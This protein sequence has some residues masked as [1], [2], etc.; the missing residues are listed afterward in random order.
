MHLTVF[1]QNLASNAI[2]HGENV[3]IS[4]TG[5]RSLYFRNHLQKFLQFI[6]KLETPLN[7]TVLIWFLLTLVYDIRIQKLSAEYYCRKS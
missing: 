6:Y 7:P 1:L 4:K 5:I 3:M 2:V